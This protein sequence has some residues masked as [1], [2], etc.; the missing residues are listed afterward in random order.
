MIAFNQ[1]ER[2]SSRRIESR[3]LNLMKKT[4]KLY[5]DVPIELCLLCEGS[6]FGE[7]EILQNSPAK[8]DVVVTSN[9]TEVY[10]IDSV[11][12]FRIMQLNHSLADRYCHKIT[13][14]DTFRKKRFHKTIDIQH[15]ANDEREPFKIKKQ[16]RTTNISTSQKQKVAKISNSLKRSEFLRSTHES[17][18]NKVKLYKRSIRPLTSKIEGKDRFFDFS[19]FDPVLR[20]RLAMRTAAE[21]KRTNAKHEAVDS[22]IRVTVESS[23]IQNAIASSRID[24]R[25]KRNFMSIAKQSLDNVEP[26]MRQCMTVRPFSKASFQS[27]ENTFLTSTRERTRSINLRASSSKGILKKGRTLS[28]VHFG[29]R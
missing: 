13:L 3:S 10:S 7:K 2:E 16:Y 22:A 27:S 6:I 18:S 26:T 20:R 4:T 5:R 8:Y 9:S 15:K 12:I 11:G 28:S 21:L 14:K 29:Q 24:I 23:I 1:E 19:S 25:T 17:I